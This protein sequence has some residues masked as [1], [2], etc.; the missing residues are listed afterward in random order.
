[1]FKFKGDHVEGGLCLVCTICYTFVM[2]IPVTVCM[3]V[4]P[5]F[6]RLAGVTC[7]FHLRAGLKSRHDF[8]VWMRMMTTTTAGVLSF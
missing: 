6:W 7:V 8:Q 5:S 3:C 2:C 4:L 1:M